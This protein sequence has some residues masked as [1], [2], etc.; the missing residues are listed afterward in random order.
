MDGNRQPHRYYRCGAIPLPFRNKSQRESERAA[1]CKTRREGEEERRCGIGG[2]RIR[3][4]NA[5]RAHQKYS[6]TDLTPRESGSSPRLRCPS[7]AEEKR[8]EKERKKKRMSPV[9]PRTP[10]CLARL[11]GCSVHQICT[12]ISS[13]L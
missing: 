9:R 12:R 13:A 6:K 10:A 5:T 7:V 8:E 11:T 4:E 1:A 3:L 2:A